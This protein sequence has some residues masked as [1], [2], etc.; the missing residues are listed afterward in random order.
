[1]WQEDWRTVVT[2]SLTPSSVIYGQPVT[3][4][5]P[6]KWQKDKRESCLFTFSFFHMKSITKRDRSTSNE[7]FRFKRF[8]KGQTVEGLSSS[9]S[10]SYY[11]E[12]AKVQHCSPSCRTRG[13]RVGLAWGSHRG[14]LDVQQRAARIWWIHDIFRPVFVS[15]EATVMPHHET[16]LLLNF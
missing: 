13:P 5:T 8:R 7:I 16:Q 10:S 14:I 15:N 2:H 9:S 4:L 3:W 12:R 1:M 11:A 6:F